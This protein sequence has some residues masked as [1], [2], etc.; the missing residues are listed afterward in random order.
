MN[1]T[2][3]RCAGTTAPNSLTSIT[4]LRS[5]S[6]ANVIGR[7]AAASARRLTTTSPATATGFRSARQVDRS[8]RSWRALKSRGMATND[9]TASRIRL[10]WMSGVVRMEPPVQAC[11]LK[12]VCVAPDFFLLSKIGRQVDNALQR[13]LRGAR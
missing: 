2:P 11:A 3:D 13:V 6:D 5:Q 4:P 12:N 9:G 7:S 8:A 1:V 10:G